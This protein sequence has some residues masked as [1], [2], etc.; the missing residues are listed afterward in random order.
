MRGKILLG[1]LLQTL[2]GKGLYVS[3]NQ[4]RVWAITRHCYFRKVAVAGK[5]VCRPLLCG[6]LG[7]K[8]ERKLSAFPAKKWKREGKTEMKTEFCKMGHEMIF[9]FQKRKNVFQ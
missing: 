3:S 5:M 8:I 9:V 4:C 6:Q 7:M 2:L 1:S